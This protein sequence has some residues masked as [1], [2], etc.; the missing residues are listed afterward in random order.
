[1]CRS[2]RCR[3][4]RARSS[5]ARTSGR[6]SADLRESGSIEQDADVVMFI[7]REEYYLERAEPVRRHED[8]QQKFNERTQTGPSA[9]AATSPRSSSPSSATARPAR[10]SCSSRA[11][12]PASAISRDDATWPDD[13][14]SDAPVGRA[15]RCRPHDR[16]RRRRRQLA[17]AGGAR[18]AGGCAAVVKADAYGLGVGRGRRRRCARPAAAPSSSPV[19]TRR[20]ALRAAAVAGA[21]DL[22]AERPAARRGAGLRAPPPAPGAERPRPRSRPG[23]RLRATRAGRRLPAV[24]PYRY[25][26]EPA[27]PAAGGGERWLATS[28]SGSTASPSPA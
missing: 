1:M 10:A 16:P 8:S 26:H 23:P 14:S 5:S 3:S 17:A 20:M 15:R 27:R 6:S 19:S 21:D 4:S 9:A 22:R 2:W 12:S 7:F 18:G 11:S 25:R 28:R 24:H 13:A